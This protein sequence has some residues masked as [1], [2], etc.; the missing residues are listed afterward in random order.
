MNKYKIE[1]KEQWSRHKED[2]KI[3]E[4]RKAYM[5]IKYQI[6][7]YENKDETSIGN[8][9]SL[10]QFFYIFSRGIC[11]LWSCKTGTYDFFEKV[12]VY[13]L[14]LDCYVWDNQSF[15]FFIQAHSILL[16]GYYYY[17]FYI[18]IYR[19]TKSLSVI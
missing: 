6:F 1:I 4:T 9:S 2:S 18:Y 3:K 7:L 16:C 15:F 17:Y 14:L 8:A 13:I 10:Y 19:E 5:Y 12:N 11:R